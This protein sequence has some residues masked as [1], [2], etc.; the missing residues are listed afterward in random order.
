MADGIHV[1]LAVDGC[2]GCPVATLSE[3]TT[4]EDLRVDSS[5][6]RVEFVTT[7]PPT[8]PPE[9]VELVD[10][11]GQTHGRYDLL[12]EPH[13]TDGG[14]RTAVSAEQGAVTGDE[15]T[16][17]TNEA[18]PASDTGDHSDDPGCDDC[19]CRGITSV[20][21]ALPV[22][23][24]ETRIEN[25]ELLLSFVLTGHEE[26]EA[27][28]DAFASVGLNAE[29]RQLIVGRDCGDDCDVVPVDLSC[30][31]TRQAEVAAIAVEQGYFE[32]GGAS[33]AEIAAELDLAKST[34]SE[35]LRIVTAT[36]FSQ[37]FAD[38]SQ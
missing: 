23:P 5:D 3:R 7:D 34:V 30:V 27:I 35:H 13:A 29:L 1:R 2:D 18:P 26:L 38:E 28:V 37:L 33:A 15:P 6:E 24:R 10:F 9:T 31:T 36:L 16:R 11:G 4:V 21:E 8:D 19:S 14:V 17:G 20:F 12:T 22:R 32:P 25:G